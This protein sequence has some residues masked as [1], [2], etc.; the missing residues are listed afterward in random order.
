MGAD[1]DGSGAIAAGE[2][3]GESGADEELAKV[4]HVGTIGTITPRVKKFVD[5]TVGWGYGPSMVPTSTTW[6]MADRLAGG[7]LADSIRDLAANDL[8]AVQIS[9]RLAE[10]HP[11]VE[12][13][14]QTI[15]NW[16]VALSPEIAS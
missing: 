11:G 7:T 2:G 12:V 3:E 6:R 1:R 4:G 13:T 14:P 9:E 10:L 5:E 15:R 8:N 16:I